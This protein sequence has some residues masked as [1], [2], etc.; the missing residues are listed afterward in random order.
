MQG[1]GV[2]AGPLGLP[3]RLVRARLSQG[4]SPPRKLGGSSVVQRVEL[5]ERYPRPACGLSLSLSDVVGL[6]HPVIGR[7][8]PRTASQRAA[9]ASIST[10]RSGEASPLTSSIVVAGGGSGRVPPTAP[11]NGPTSAG[12]VR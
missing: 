7:R 12:S 10:R 2:Q 3:L 8:V 9:T 4:V 5:R 6:V 1:C 11:M